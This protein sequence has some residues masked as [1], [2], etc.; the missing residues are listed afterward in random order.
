MW[1][2][3][4]PSAQEQLIMHWLQ[5]F[6][7][8][9]FSVAQLLTPENERSGWHRQFSINWR[10]LRNKKRVLPHQWHLPFPLFGRESVASF[11]NICEWKWNAHVCTS[12][13][14]ALYKYTQFSLSFENPFRRLHFEGHRMDVHVLTTLTEGPC[15]CCKWTRFA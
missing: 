7:H 11:E 10:M 3:K 2:G 15:K 1:L 13:H 9:K 5:H 14:F 8:E 12:V 4:P 6:V